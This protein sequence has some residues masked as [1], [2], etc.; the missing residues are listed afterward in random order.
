VCVC[1]LNFSAT[2]IIYIRKNQYE[3]FLIASAVSSNGNE[4]SAVKNMVMEPLSKKKVF[5]FVCRWE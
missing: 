2:K 5:V 4:V 3:P 1:V